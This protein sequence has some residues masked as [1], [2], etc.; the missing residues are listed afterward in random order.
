MPGTAVIRKASHKSS[1]GLIV[2][3]GYVA[4]KI[5]TGSRLQ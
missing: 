1:F 4:K 3:Q 5:A 2:L